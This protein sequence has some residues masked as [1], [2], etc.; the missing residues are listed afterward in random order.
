VTLVDTSV[1]VT[2]KRGLNAAL[3]AALRR[4][5]LADQALGHDLIF[6]ELLLGAGGDTRRQL[7]DDYRRLQMLDTVPDADVATF[8]RDHRLENRGI[9]AVDAHILAA[10]HAGRATVWTL[11]RAMDKAAGALRL[12]FVPDAR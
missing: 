8:C 4:L 11:D 12:A 5:V 7:L 2:A 10:A 6:L 3:V 9:G 1:W